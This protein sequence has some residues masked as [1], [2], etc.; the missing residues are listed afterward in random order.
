MVRLHEERVEKFNAHRAHQDS[1]Y[2]RL[3]EHRARVREVPCEVCGADVNQKC[4]TVRG[5]GRVSLHLERILAWK[6]AQ[7]V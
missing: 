1:E 2:R 7:C 4:L 6:A 5:G 3:E